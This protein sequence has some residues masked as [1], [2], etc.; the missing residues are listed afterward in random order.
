MGN[1]VIGLYC[2]MILLFG[3]LIFRIYYITQSDYLT[4]ASNEQ[5]RYSLD[6]TT[7][8]GAIYD[9]NMKPLVDNESKSIAAIMPCTEAMN[10][11][12][13]NVVGEQ[14]NIALER[15]KKPT[16]FLMELDRSKLYSQGI[17]MFSVT[18]RYSDNQLAP[19]IIGYTN[20]STDDG[21]CGIEMSCN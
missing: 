6:I 2:V 10:N 21:V 14:R 18:K 9:C 15:M 17:N 4:K 1:R 11:I 5:S 19:H 7:T 12:A 16:P 3:T 13:A 20:N 8:R